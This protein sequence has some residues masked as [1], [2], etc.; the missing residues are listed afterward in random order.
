MTL[1]Q[2]SALHRSLHDQLV[3]SVYIDGTAT[4][5]SIQ[6]LWRTQLDNALTDIREWLAGSRHTEREDFDKCARL[7]DETLAQFKHG[8]GAPGFV[9]F[10]TRNGV[11][12]SHTLPVPVP[13]FA[14]WSTGPA[15][16]P[17]MR[18][19]KETR[20]V[21]VILADSSKAELYKYN[22]GKIEKLDTVRSHH[23]VEPPSHMGGPPRQ[24]FHTGT[25]GSTGRDA[26]QKSLLEGRDQM[27]DE[28]VKRATAASEEDGFIMVGGIKG[29]AKRIIANLDASVG[30][31]ALELKGLD[32]HASNA[33]IAEAVKAAAS[34]LRASFDSKRIAEIA[35][36]AAAGGL[37]ALGPEETRLA[38]EQAS[39]RDLYLTHRYLEDHAAEAEDA[40]RSALDQ[41]AS[42][43]EVS[44][45]AAEDLQRVGGMA[46]GLRFRPATLENWGAT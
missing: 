41:H 28:V 18:A 1:P 15:V 40:V 43:E 14:I 10:I 23:V 42:V 33:K 20:P 38:L 22:A 44:H 12:E 46:A 26:A 7:L 39:V 17:Y 27:V 19:M 16:A 30:G 8:F 29:V 36:Q 3:L 11:V 25:R 34:E 2:L 4:D 37:G 6:H 24:G 35:D 31:R 13:T 5:F 21:T 45:E 9:S 32:I